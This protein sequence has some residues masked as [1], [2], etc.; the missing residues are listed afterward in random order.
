MIGVD[1]KDYKVRRQLVLYQTG[2]KKEKKKEHF[3][4]FLFSEKNKTIH[5]VS[6]FALQV[7]NLHDWFS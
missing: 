5:S 7:W 4:L 6:T 3:M 2:L 1:L